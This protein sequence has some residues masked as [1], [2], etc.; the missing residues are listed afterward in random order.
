[1]RSVSD[2]SEDGRKTAEATETGSGRRHG[3]SA[4]LRLLMSLEGQ[5]ALARTAKDR[6]TFLESEIERIRHRRL[7]DALKARAYVLIGCFLAAGFVSAALVWRSLPFLG[8][9]F[10]FAVAGGA[11]AG[12]THSPTQDDATLLALESDLEIEEAKNLPETDR[13]EKLLKNHRYELQR[14]AAQTLQQNRWIFAV[15]LLCLGAGFTAIVVTFYLIRSSGGANFQEKV[16]I[17]AIGAV[18]SILANF[19]GAV[20]LRM[21]S[22]ITKAATGVHGKLV[23]AHN[24][25]FA[26]LLCSRITEPKIRQETYAAMAKSLSGKAHADPM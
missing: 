6:K 16:L 9:A 4:A 8:I 20:Y 5:P 14:Y 11:L 12:I 24:L 17:A 19:V 21:F 1:M 7:R 23:A 3:V 15:G 2:N 10:V 22:E 26:D 25:Y 13:A 18:G